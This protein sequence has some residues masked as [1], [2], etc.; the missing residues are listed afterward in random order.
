MG[1][2]GWWHP[3]ASFSYWQFSCS[4]L[5]PFFN[6]F[7]PHSASSLTAGWGHCLPSPLCLPSPV[8]C[9]PQLLP[10]W[11]CYDAEGRRKPTY[12]LTSYPAILV[13][14]PQFSVPYH[15]FTTL[16]LPSPTP[17]ALPSARWLL[18]HSVGTSP[19][20]PAYL[21]TFT[22][23][24]GRPSPIPLYHPTYPTFSLPAIFCGEGRGGGPHLRLQFILSPSPMGYPEN[25]RHGHGTW[26]CAWFV[27]FSGTLF[28]ENKATT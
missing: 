3:A 25:G 5:L 2:R 15:A 27:W 19:A 20:C 16:T 11:S 13:L 28:H 1:R 17:L 14:L 21:P 6:S 24:R 26:H 12:L 4:P 22:C 10:S 8:P 9:L 7:L 23:H 18:E